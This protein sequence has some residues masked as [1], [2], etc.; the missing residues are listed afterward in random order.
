SWSITDESIWAN[1][2]SYV[3]PRDKVLGA[4]NGVMFNDR[5]ASGTLTASLVSGVSHGALWL[6]SAGSFPHPPSAGYTGGD[7]FTHSLSDGRTHTA[8]A[9]ATLSVTDNHAPVGNADTYSVAHN[10]TLSVAA[11]AGVLANDT[12]DDLVDSLTA[13]LVS[14]PSHG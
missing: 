5:S 8:T 10:H 9:T 14:G 4:S 7:S 13:S 3:V 1:P 6:A 11:S 2:D 12:D